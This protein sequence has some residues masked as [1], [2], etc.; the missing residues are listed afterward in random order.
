M[1]AVYTKGKLINVNGRF[2]KDSR[3]VVWEVGREGHREREEDREDKKR[4]KIRKRVKR[5]MRGMV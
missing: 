3:E 4:I 5:R 2:Q 1:Y